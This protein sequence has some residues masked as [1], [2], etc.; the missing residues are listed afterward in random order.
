MD[1]EDCY[2]EILKNDIIK[3]DESSMSRG[4]QTRPHDLAHSHPCQG[5]AQRR[6]RL[7]VAKS[8]HSQS[9]VRFSRTMHQSKSSLFARMTSRLMIFSFFVFTLMAIFF[10]LYWVVTNN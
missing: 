2:A 4:A 5:T 6:I 10:C 3:L 1:E 9:G 7:R 8:T